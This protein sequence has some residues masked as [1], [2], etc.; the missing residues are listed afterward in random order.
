MRKHKMSKEEKVTLAITTLVCLLPIIVAVILYKKIPDQIATHWDINGNPNGWSD[1]LKGT[2]IYPG[3][4]VLVNLCMPFLMRLDPKYANM[5]R[6]LKTLVQ[7]IIPICCIFCSSVT[8]MAALGMEVHVEQ[9][10]PL[11]FGFLFIVIG[12]WLPKTKQSYTLGIKLP[13][14]LDNEENWNK[15]HRIGGFCFVLAGVVM[16]VSS[17]FSWRGYALAFAILLAVIVPTFYSYYLYR[18]NNR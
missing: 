16:V 8:L 1:K 6:K 7:W 9:F 2:I 10:A 15:T 11:L 13:W 17:F 18:K 5:D 3:I 4:L 12:N 14:T